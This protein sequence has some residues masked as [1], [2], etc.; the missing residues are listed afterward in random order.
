MRLS[1][2][3][4]LNEADDDENTGGNEDTNANDTGND[5]TADDNAGDNNTTDN[6][7]N[8]NDDNF[9]IDANLDD[10]SGGDDTGGDDF[11]SDLGGDS[12]GGGEAEFSQS[13]DEEINKD[14][15]DIFSSLTKEEQFMKIRELKN[16]YA[17]LYRAC[18]D[19]LSRLND[20][21]TEDELGLS[22]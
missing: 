13:T 10:N 8:K 9:D 14:N 17:D 18:D 12:G 4:Y 7:D 22:S 3:L 15:T 2:Y 6:N 16:L 11:G 5:D 19:Q 20:I 1:D 21:D